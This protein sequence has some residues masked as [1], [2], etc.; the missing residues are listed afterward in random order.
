VR[1]PVGIISLFFTAIMLSHYTK[2]NLTP[3]AGDVTTSLFKTLAWM[4]EGKQPHP[5]PPPINLAY[6]QASVVG[7][8]GSDRECRRCFLL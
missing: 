6:T 3:I 2:H 8:H 7:V 5:R 4:A 1:A